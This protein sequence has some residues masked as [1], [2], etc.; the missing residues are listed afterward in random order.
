VQTKK[1]ARI[2]DIQKMERG[3]VKE[4]KKFEEVNVYAGVRHVRMGNGWLWGQ[5]LLEKR[6]EGM[7]RVERLKRAAGEGENAAWLASAG[8]RA[9]VRPALIYMGG[10]GSEDGSNP[11]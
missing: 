5:H 8:W 6:R 2:W 3:V 7:W 9:I 4:S 1:T 11:E 10:G